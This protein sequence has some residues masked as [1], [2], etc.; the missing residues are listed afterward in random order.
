MA[1]KLELAVHCAV[2]AR[3][4]VGESPVWSASEQ[5]LYWVDIV[6]PA[7]Y[8][9]HPASGEWREWPM[10]AAVGSIGL[11]QSGGLVLAMRTGFHLFDPATEGAAPTFVVHPEADRPTNRL[12]DGKVAPDGSFWAGTMDDRPQKEAVAALYRLGADYRCERMAGGLKVSNGLAWSP[13]G[14]VLYHSDSRGGVIWRYAHDPATGTIGAKELFVEVR[15]EW[16]RPD[17]GA[18]D[19]EGCYWSCGVSAGRINR[20]SPRGE[21]LSH[22]ELPVT[23]PTMPCFGGPELKTLFVTSLREGLTEAQLDQEPFAGG[24]FRIE[25]DVPGVP[26]ALYRG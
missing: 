14:R 11:R 16:G 26:V 25:V 7:V 10:P 17:G 24:V 6:K 8:R 5:A 23:H 20:F 2:D 12:N 13:D 4:T 3:N 21:L 15:S 1:S 18:T 19:A 9:W 22:I